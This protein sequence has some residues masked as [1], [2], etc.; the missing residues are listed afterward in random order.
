M[1]IAQE[2]LANV[3]RHSGADHCRLLWRHDDGRTHLEIS[4]DG[5]GFRASDS[6]AGH[7]G[8]TGMEE[9]A[10]AMKAGIS[11]WSA[12]GRGTRISVDLDVPA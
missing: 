4:D 11:I 2:A 10:A 12:P 3:A 5:R 9:R 7:F 6:R 8:L 1:R